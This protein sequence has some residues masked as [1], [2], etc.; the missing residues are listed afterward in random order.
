MLDILR[1]YYPT[2]FNKALAAWL[3]VSIRSLQ[4]KANELGLKKVDDFNQVRA[5]GISELLSDALKK[6]YREG[7]MTQ[8]F[9]KGI[10]SNPEGEFKP[11]HKF[12]EKTEQERKEKIRRTFKKR[13]MLK[14]YGL[15][16]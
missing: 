4:R 6:A 1:T 5:E 9:P 11:G 2:M 8:G 7:R 12:D 14:I 10:R 3:K 16:R 15:S 13:K